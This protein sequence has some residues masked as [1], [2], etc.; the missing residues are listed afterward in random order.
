MV[1]PD[2]REYGRSDK[3]QAVESY[4]LRVMTADGVAVL[5]DLG[6]GQAHVVAHDRGAWRYEQ[7]DGPGH[8][9]Q[10]EAPDQVNALLLNF[11]PR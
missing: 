11:L 1:V 9:L 4:R 5:A 6:I 7:L 8:W 3:P 2:L 10:L